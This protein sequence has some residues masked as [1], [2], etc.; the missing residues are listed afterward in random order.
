MGKKRNK[1]VKIYKKKK[2]NVSCMGH[3]VHGCS[4]GTILAGKES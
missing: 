4:P 3:S 1:K 2:K